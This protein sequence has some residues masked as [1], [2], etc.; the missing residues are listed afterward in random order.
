MV[1]YDRGVVAEFGRF[2][3]VVGVIQKQ[4]DMVNGYWLFLGCEMGKGWRL[5]GFLWCDGRHGY[6]L[7]MNH[8]VS[9]QRNNMLSLSVWCSLR[10][11][12]CD[13]S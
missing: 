9:H 1:K 8:R 11:G 12:L 2:H 10:V 7:D 6:S 4:N 13:L 5:N 3:E